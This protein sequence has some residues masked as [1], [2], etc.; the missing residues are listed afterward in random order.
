VKPL[1]I[2]LS[3]SEGTLD[4]VSEREYSGKS[5]IVTGKLG[6]ESE[7]MKVP[8]TDFCSLA[9]LRRI[10]PAKIKLIKIDIEG[11]E[12]EVLLGMRRTLRALPAAAT[13][14]CE[15]LGNQEEK[16]AISGKM[17]E[18]GFAHRPLETESDFLFWRTHA[19]EAP[20]LPEQQSDFKLPC[21]PLGA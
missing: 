20:T 14:I 13:I 19:I 1:N 21:W 6:A 7:S 10:D 16:C 17:S 3:S 8:V 9:G 18:L 15:I 12:F 2:G 11:H 5:R 4:F